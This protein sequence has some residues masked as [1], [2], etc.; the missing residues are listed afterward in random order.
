MPFRDIL[1]LYRKAFRADK[2]SDPVSFE[3]LSDMWLSTLEIGARLQKSRQNH[4]SYVCEALSGIVFTPA[5]KRSVIVW[6]QP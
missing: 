1:K 3:H 2:K 4:R 6:K 5:Q